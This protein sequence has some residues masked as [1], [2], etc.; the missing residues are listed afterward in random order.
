MN[1][2]P[3][4]VIGG[5]PHA[6]KSVLFYSLTHALRERQIPHH[7]IRACLDGEGNWSQEAPAEIVSQ[8]RLSVKTEWPASFI[9]RISQDIEHRC[10]PFLIDMGGRP[11]GKQLE[12]FRLATHAILLLRADKPEDTIMWQR[13]IQENS[14]VPLAQLV[15]IQ[16]RETQ[17]TSLTPIL[18]GTINRLERHELT[19]QHG[20]TFEHLVDL[21]AQLFRSYTPKELDTAE[22]LDDAYFQPELGEVINLKTFIAPEMEWKP[23]MLPCLLAHIPAGAAFA[24]Y[25]VAPTWVYAAAAAAGQ[26]ALSQ[27]DPKLPF[28]WVRPLAVETSLEQHPDTRME[29]QSTATATILSIQI[30]T[31]LEYFQPDPFPLPPVDATQGLIISG[32]IPYWLITAIVRHYRDQRLPW[33]AIYSPQLN[34]AIVVSSRT[35]IYQP[36][37]LLDLTT[38]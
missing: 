26:Q 27:F 5:P 20:Q 16:Q 38:V 33:L 22:E 13:F 30:P 1:L 23:E 25:G 15:S 4:V 35:N 18:E 28:G 32:R 36:G 11:R 2:L 14:V 6:G 34:K 21:V 37:T 17:L 29:L 24:L 3:A 8:I 10:L 12:L 31:R 7:A 9:D 19:R